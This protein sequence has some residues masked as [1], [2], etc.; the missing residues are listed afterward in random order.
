METDI[1]QKNIIKIICNVLTLHTEMTWA[2]F[3]YIQL[4]QKYK[5]IT[6]K[7]DINPAIDIY[8]Y[9]HIYD[10]N[11]EK[12]LDS[13]NILSK[14]RYSVQAIYYAFIDPNTRISY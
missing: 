2:D 8:W 3:K 11:W 1:H 13:W 5:P 4:G 14:N 9:K 12:K 10:I 7:K 6:I